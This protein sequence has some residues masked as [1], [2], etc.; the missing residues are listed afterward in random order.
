MFTLPK[1]NYGYADLE[2]YIDAQ[3]MEI[4]HSKHH[5]AYLDKLNSAFEDKDY[6]NKNLTG[7]LSDLDSI[8]EDKR[9]LV[10]NNGGGHWN[11]STFWRFMTPGGSEFSG[12][13]AELINS[14]YGTLEKF[15]EE[16]AAAAVSRFG[17]G[18]VWLLKDGSGVKIVSTPNQ[19]NPIM[20]G[21]SQSDI[22]LCLDV[23]E[24]AY[25]LKY[26]NRRPEYVENW[27][28]VV[29]WQAINSMLV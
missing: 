27:W 17:S 9:M 6:S 26:Q 23:W 22:L 11:H 15:E 18:W 16:F 3:T 2:P 24:H 7:I 14:Q 20:E 1:L 13:I 29:D 25:Y 19:D 5:Q 8:D 12:N 21:V 28:N 4:H 10:R